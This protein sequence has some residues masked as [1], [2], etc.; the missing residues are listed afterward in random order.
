MSRLDDLI[1][2]YT[3]LYADA[4]EGLKPMYQGTLLGIQLASGAIAMDRQ[5]EY[6]RQ[7]DAL[8]AQVNNLSAA[9]NGGPNW[10]RPAP[11]GDRRKDMDQLVE[12]YSLTDPRNGTVFY[13]GSASSAVDQVRDYTRTPNAKVSCKPILSELQ[14]EQLEPIVEVLETGIRLAEASAAKAKWMQAMAASGAQ[15]TNQ[16]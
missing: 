3:Q 16:R 13:V 11:A 8:Q 10:R 9:A 1:N 5:E 14:E 6:Q 2:Q 15:L 12:V 7:V 4:P